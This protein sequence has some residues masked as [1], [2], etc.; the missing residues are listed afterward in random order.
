[1]GIPYCLA[2]HRRQDGW[3]GAFVPS[4]A[5]VFQTDLSDLKTL[6]FGDC[7]IVDRTSKALA[8]APGIDTTLPCRPI[9]HNDERLLIQALKYVQAASDNILLWCY[10]DMTEL[11]RAAVGHRLCSIMQPNTG[12]DVKFGAGRTSNA[13]P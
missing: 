10:R 3:G 1:V 7:S 13:V 6:C 11:P 9:F 8:M 4:M 12:A 2:A 5:Q